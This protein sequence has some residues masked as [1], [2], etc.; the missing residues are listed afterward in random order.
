MSTTNI[1]QLVQQFVAVWNETDEQRRR[2]DVRALWTS[3]GRHL[4]GPHDVRGHD[5]LVERVTASHRR[6]AEGGCVFRPATSI[7]LLPGVA[8]F[9]WDMARRSTGEVVSAGVGFLLLSVDGRIEC[10][11]LFTES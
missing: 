2:E 1:E 5:A 9:R 10:D 8:K 4:M 3:Q 6:S 7:Q 11:C